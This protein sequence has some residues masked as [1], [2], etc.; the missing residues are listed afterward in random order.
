MPSALYP[1]HLKG[2]K[3]SEMLVTRNNKQSFMRKNSRHQV[4][5]SADM[6]CRG[7]SVLEIIG[8]T[9]VNKHESNRLGE[10]NKLFRRSPVPIINEDKV[11]HWLTS[12]FRMDSTP[13]NCGTYHKVLF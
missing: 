5:C 10:P 4:E 7:L 6:N 8:Q 11:V 3:E 9:R 1:Q 13:L 2:K 12:D